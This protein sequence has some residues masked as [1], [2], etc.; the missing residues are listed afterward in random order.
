MNEISIY[1]SIGTQEYTDSVLVPM[2]TGFKDQ[3]INFRINSPGG[4]VFQGL[5]IYNSIKNHGQCDMYIDGVAASMASIIILAGRKIYAA[6][7]AMIM[8]H[9]PSISE[10]EG[11]SKKLKSLVQLL[12]KVKKIAID[13]YSER[14][15]LDL[16]KLSEMLDNETWL[17]AEEA[18]EMGFIDAITDEVFDIDSIANMKLKTPQ[19]LFMKY[20]KKKDNNPKSLTTIL[21]LSSN[22]DT[23]TIFN[24]I[25]NLKNKSVLLEAENKR[26]KKEIKDEQ[27]EE[28]KI[29]VKLAIDKGVINK[30]LERVQLMA[31]DKDFKKTKADLQLAISEVE[32]TNI[33]GRNH[34]I[35]KEI[36]LGATK[37]KGIKTLDNVVKPKS[38]W[39]LHDYRKHAPEDLQNS[40]E[41]YKEL[42]DKEYK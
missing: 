15:N 14:T 2:I 19:K 1:G 16:D 22:S 6:K 25:S 41:L 10:F 12:E 20:K 26:I 13:N 18:L 37:G 8:I 4:D 38:E 5:A 33:Q 36:V 11:D 39:T 32:T 42:I 27:M 29:M 17:T 28:A 21:G 40:P 23:D 7:N 24:A 3:E 31:F 9:N 34:S 35:I 30:N